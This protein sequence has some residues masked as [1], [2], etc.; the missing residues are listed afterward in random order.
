VLDFEHRLRQNLRALVAQ[1]ACA[2]WFNLS[3]QLLGGSIVGVCALCMVLTIP[4]SSAAA[5]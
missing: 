4:G 1:Q 3:L 2:A 5:G